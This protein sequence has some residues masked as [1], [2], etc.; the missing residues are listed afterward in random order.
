MRGRFFQ[1]TF[2]KEEPQLLRKAVRGINATQFAE[3]CRIYLIKVSSFCLGVIATARSPTTPEEGITLFHFQVQQPS[4]QES[5]E[6]RRHR[7]KFAEPMLK[8]ASGSNLAADHDWSMQ[9]CPDA[10]GAKARRARLFDGSTGRK[11]C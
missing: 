10:D 7:N 6:N 4:L 5:L 2:C 8:Q 9:G 1:P 3:L 11:S